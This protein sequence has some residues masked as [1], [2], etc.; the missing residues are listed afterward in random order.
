MSRVTDREVDALVDAVV[1]ETMRLLA[2]PNSIG[3]PEDVR[4]SMAVIMAYERFLLMGSEE[5]DAVIA[6]R[7]GAA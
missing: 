2:Q 7:I 4:L 6:A 1:A 5:L 3:L